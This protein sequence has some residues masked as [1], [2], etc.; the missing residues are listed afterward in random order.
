MSSILI[1]GMKKIFFEKKNNF[2][3]VKISCS[4]F[5]K[6][7][8]LLRRLFCRSECERLIGWKLLACIRFLKALNLEQEF[9]TLFFFLT[10]EVPL[11]HRFLTRSVERVLDVSYITCLGSQV[12]HWDIFGF[13]RAHFRTLG[14][15]PAVYKS[16]LYNSV[17]RHWSHKPGVVSSILTG[18]NNL[19]KNF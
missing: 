9:S 2:S 4:F 12:V 1:G 17:V 18:G 5:L 3:V 19:E 11:H 15:Q 13:R 10:S 7:L 16:S 6:S 8:F 14:V